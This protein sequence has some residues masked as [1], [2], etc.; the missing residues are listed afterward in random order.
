MNA[1]IGRLSSFFWRAGRRRAPTNG[2]GAASCQGSWAPTQ[3]PSGDSSRPSS[4]ADRNP[5]RP[6]SKKWRRRDLERSALL[7]PRPQRRE[8]TPPPP[9][10]PPPS[11][12]EPL[13]PTPPLR[14]HRCSRR[15]WD[16][17][18]T[19]A[20]VTPSQPRSS[21]GAPASSRPRLRPRSLRAAQARSRRRC[22]NRN[23]SALPREQAREHAL[24]C[25]TYR[26]VGGRAVP[27]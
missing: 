15:K 3:T 21:R 19:M 4:A 14:Q 20:L 18:Y 25:R 10:H 8:E 5:R 17:R 16:T 2:I 12:E 7:A 6:L 1:D 9:R 13:L 24:G 11:R 26:W 23:A 27:V 22:R